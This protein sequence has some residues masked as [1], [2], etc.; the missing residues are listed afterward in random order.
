[1]QPLPEKVLIPEAVGTPVCLPFL[2]QESQP[3]YPAG[4]SQF[5]KS[6]YILFPLLYRLT[7]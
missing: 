4:P 2:R 1:M 5:H 7:L 3:S 6:G